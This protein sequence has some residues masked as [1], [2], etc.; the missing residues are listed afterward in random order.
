MEDADLILNLKSISLEILT[1]GHMAK[2][3]WCTWN[4]PRPSS[5]EEWDKKG[6]LIFIT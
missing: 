5:L 1:L 2:C 6:Y 3:D 4:N